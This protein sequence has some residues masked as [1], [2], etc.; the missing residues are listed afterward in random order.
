MVASSNY[1]RWT[2]SADLGALVALKNNRDRIYLAPEVG[3]LVL[4]DAQGRATAR[5]TSAGNSE[6]PMIVAKDVAEAMRAAGI[7][8]RADEFISAAPLSTKRSVDAGGT[9]G[10]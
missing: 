5:A 6:R 7:E 8:F 9:W 1:V 4:S 10:E 3:N 2:V